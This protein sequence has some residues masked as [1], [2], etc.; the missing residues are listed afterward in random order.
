MRECHRATTLRYLLISFLM[1]AVSGHAVC[2]QDR[3]PPW[4]S[5]GEAEDTARKARP[6]HRS[7]PKV[8]NSAPAI[9]AAA[10]QKP[11][12]PAGP[13]RAASPVGPP[14]VQLEK[15]ASTPEAAINTVS[16]AEARA[17][18]K[19]EI[20]PQIAHSAKV[21]SVAFSP[22]GR[23]VLSGSSDHTVKLWDAATGELVRTF[24]GHVRE[25]TSVAFSPAGRQVLSGSNDGTMKLWDATTGT[26]VHTFEGHSDMV[27][28]V[29][30]SPDGRQVLSGSSD[31]TVRLW[32]AAMGKVVHTFEGHA[33]MVFSVAFSPDG[34]QVLSGGKDNTVR[35]WDAAT[36]EVVRTFEGHSDIV[37]SV[38]F[39]PEGRQVRSGSSDKTVKLWDAATG[40]VVR[41][42]DWDTATGEVVRTPPLFTDS[43][44]AFSPDG[45][46]F[47]A[48]NGD[49]TFS[50]F[51]A[52]VGALVHTFAG[53][54]DG[55]VSVAFSPDGRQVLSGSRDTTVSLW[56]AATGEIVRTFEGHASGVASV[57]FSPDGR[58]LLSGSDDVRL[59]DAVTGQIV[60]NFGHE[61]KWNQVYSVA[62]SPDGRQVLSGSGDNTAK[63][64]DAVTGQVVRS[65]EGHSSWVTAVAFSP[66]GRQVLSG[67]GDVRLWDAATGQVVRTFEGHQ[68]FIHSVAFSPAGRQ[69][70]SGSDDG[71]MKLWDALT[72]Q[73]VRNFEPNVRQVF[74]VAFSPDGQQV[75][76]S[77][78]ENKTFVV[79]SG[80]EDKTI[81]LWHAA[82]V[83]SL[84]TFNGHSDNVHSVA[85]SPNGRQV[86][87]GSSDKTVKLWDA[88]TGEVVR[89]FEGHS[90]SV[91][92]VAF[93]PDGQRVLSGSDDTTTRLWKTET[94]ELLVTFIG[95]RDGEWL[96]LTP[97]GFFNASS[98]KAAPLLGIVR[99]L[100]AYSL[101]QMWQS[102]YAPDLVRE[103]LA[104]DPNGEVAK[105]A[106]VTSLDKVID[107]GR[108]PKVAI[109]SPVSGAASADEI[110]TAEA[111]IAAQEGGIG[112]VEW[113]VNGV[114][115][116]VSNPSPGT[117]P[118]ITAKQTLALDPGDN[119]IE[120]V[121]YNGRNL[122]ASLPAESKITWTGTVATKPKLH[123]LSIGINK[124]IDK[125]GTGATGFKYF[126]PLDLAVPD[127]LA[128]AGALERA[129]YTLYGEVRVRT[130]LDEEATAA[131]LDAIVTE[132]AADIA[133]RDTF[134]LFAAAHGY[135]YQGRFYLIPQDYQG[136]T[137]PQALVAHAIDQ[138]K[139]QDW[140]TNRIRAK[141]AL[142]LLDSC[143]S[144]AL[145][146]GY[147]RSRFDGPASDA[148][149]GRL[150]EAIGRPVLTA[151]GLGQSALEITELGH[152]V[153]TSALIDSFYRGDAN[154]DGVVSVSELVAHVQDLVERLIVDPKVRAE[155]VHRGLIG[156]A[157]S[158]QFG[159]RGEDFAFVHR[160]Q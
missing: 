157:Q 86:L 18:T 19:T 45:R 2:A 39:S 137:D 71:T 126:P 20:A 82:A 79:S 37:F 114:T 43:S 15:P 65:F 158:A 64:W 55:V 51:D 22:D 84:R 160:I 119:T 33:D 77:G 12:A 52:A 85:F 93:S 11:A 57:A 156:G 3:W 40:K 121:A 92:S 68:N 67:S 72:G 136:G 4:Q 123:L 63:L 151:A 24:V 26:V 36:G 74:S 89:T 34:R 13:E 62:F 28:S 104:G 60:R 25:I 76:S 70:L 66:D 78:S 10:E 102:L 41:T 6:K 97:E 145:T 140:F 83:K 38:A 103:K 98:P 100:D 131:N 46:Q 59:W 44:V 80:S 9:D 132:M 148:A 56:D 53:H 154:S 99:G 54:T 122:L 87:S 75:L 73:V 120:I 32:D 147:S 7:Q 47:L 5:F 1:V 42:F 61:G 125:G 113:R 48:K 21:V 14:T 138:L 29:A 106:T 96:V 23:Q 101:D 81:E 118:T 117:S 31:K 130:V 109:V 115:V 58:Q 129:S 105:A 107:S 30:F 133:P 149:I 152:G 134:V 139:I 150:H 8:E 116:G 153:F 95:A 124:Y 16:M 128:L 141:R 135:S 35:L 94:G 110:I 146:S 27:F 88:A 127:A 49:N 144:G 111:T 91:T 90:D 112:R 155:V 69:V 159:G 17:E 50:L 142:I 143:E 108:A